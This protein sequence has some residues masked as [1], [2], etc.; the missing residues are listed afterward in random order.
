MCASVRK[1]FSSFPLLPSNSSID[2]WLDGDPSLKGVVS[3]LYFAIQMIASPSL[4]HI[5][6]AWEEDFG[7]ESSDYSWQL[8]GYI[9]LL[10]VSDTVCF[11]LKCFIGSIFLGAG[12]PRYIQ[13]ASDAIRP[14]P[15]FIICSGHAN[16]SF[17]SGPLFLRH[18]PIFA[19]KRSVLAQKL[20]YLVWP[21]TGRWCQLPIPMP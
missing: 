10:F 1:H 3:R 15:P 8:R 12:L 9:Q 21:L 18:S 16:G 14:Q 7:C 19:T 11:N 5:R 13:L 2:E 6:S 20:L 17:N 4:N